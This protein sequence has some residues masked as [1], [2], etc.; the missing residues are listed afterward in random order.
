[1][2]SAVAPKHSGR[3]ASQLNITFI[4]STS[5]AGTPSQA[6]PEYGCPRYGSLSWRA[7]HETANAIVGTVRH[8]GL[9]LVPEVNVMMP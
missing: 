2:T 8:F 1:M 3:M 6:S 7:M 9:P 4:A 5:P